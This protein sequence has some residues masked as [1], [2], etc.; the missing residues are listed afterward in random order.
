MMLEVNL[1][2]SLGVAGWKALLILSVYLTYAGF[3]NGA[4]GLIMDRVGR[5]KMFIIGLVGLNP[6]A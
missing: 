6:L 3:L 5:R 4:G 2:A 1:L